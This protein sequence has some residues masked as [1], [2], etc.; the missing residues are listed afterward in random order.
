[1]D[2]TSGTEESGHCRDREV[3]V[4]ERLKQKWMYKLSPTTFPPPPHGPPSQKKQMAI[5]ERWTSSQS[6][7]VYGE[8][9]LLR[10]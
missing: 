4:I 2:Y 8:V 9:S 6:F 3:T 5:V 1:M 7:E 10:T